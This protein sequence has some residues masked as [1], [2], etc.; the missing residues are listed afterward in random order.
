MQTAKATALVCEVWMEVVKAWL[1]NPCDF[2]DS[3]RT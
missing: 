1:E 3:C 2:T